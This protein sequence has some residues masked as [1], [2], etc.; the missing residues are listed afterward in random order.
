MTN[1]YLPKNYDIFIGL[2]VD[3]T[4]FAF[5][6]YDHFN[7]NRSKKIPADPDNLINYVENHFKDQRVIC[8]YEAGP[9]GFHLYDALIEK[10]IPCLV[11]SPPSIPKP[12]NQKVKNNRIDSRKLARLLKNGELK[13]IFVPQGVF[14]ELRHLVKSY[15]LY[16]RSRGA[17]KRRIKALL[18]SAHLP[19]PPKDVK[20]NWSNPYIQHL[21][22]LSCSPVVRQRLDLLLNDLTYARKNTLI[23]TRQLRS[24]CSQ[25]LLLS[26]YIHYLQSIDGIGF[27]TAVCILG[28]IGDPRNLSN[29]RQLAGFCGLVPS[30]HSTGNRIKQGSITHLGDGYLRSLIVEA[31]WI[32]IRKNQRLQQF[33]GRIKQRH[34][35]KIASRKAIVAVARKLTQIIYCLLKEQRCCI[36]H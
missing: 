10:G 14:R 28:K 21:N 24:F 35:P 26:D 12:P 5:T 32:A 33:F 30:E 13:S 23:V 29:C 2:D 7:M 22:K 34:H 8:A 27:V 20:H 31:A 4:S 9:T 1:H 6:V 3:K 18:L 17:A 19:Q 16:S 36:A 15:Q 11:V 25:H